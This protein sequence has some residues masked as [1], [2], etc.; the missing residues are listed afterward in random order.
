MAY[1]KNTW[2]TGDVVTSA[3]LNH[4]EDGIA[5]GEVMV[6]NATVDESAS[7]LDKTW[8]EI[9]DAL[10]A[11]VMVIV[12]VALDEYDVTQW[13][14]YRAMY[15]DFTKTYS[16]MVAHYGQTV[17]VASFDSK[18]ADGYPAYKMEDAPEDN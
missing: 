5:S 9:R 17:S 13:M 7:T 3:K 11:G 16:V 1:E 2:K 18:S 12:A 4:M 15:L 10:A 14:C 6:V 8:Q